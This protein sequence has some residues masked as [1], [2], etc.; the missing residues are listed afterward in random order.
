MI[1]LNNYRSSRRWKNRAQIWIKKKKKKIKSEFIETEG[2]Q[3]VSKKNDNLLQKVLSMDVVRK[4]HMSWW[5]GVGLY[6]SK[7]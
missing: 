7:D 1:K 2:E 4:H 3:I 6:Y 5:R